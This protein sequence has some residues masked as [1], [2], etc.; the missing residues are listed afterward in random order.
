[1]KVRVIR[2]LLPAAA[3]LA[4]AACGGSGGGGTSFIPSPPVTPTPASVGALSIPPSGIMATTDFATTDDN[5]RIRWNAELKA[6]EVQLPGY[7]AGKIVQTSFGPFG[8]SGD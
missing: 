3:A 1:M 4:V 8:A 2:H 6:Y 5:V 7:P